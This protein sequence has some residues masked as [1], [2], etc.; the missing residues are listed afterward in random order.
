[1]IFAYCFL[2]LPWNDKRIISVF[3][4]FMIERRPVW[5]TI[6]YEFL[7]INEFLKLSLLLKTILK[8]I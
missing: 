4:R 7:T 6:T 5:K 8:I 1:M 3:I 2:K